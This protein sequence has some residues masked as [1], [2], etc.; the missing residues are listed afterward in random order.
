MRFP[1]PLPFSPP[2]PIAELKVVVVP[3][4]QRLR[5]DFGSQAHPRGL[6]PRRLARHLLSPP[7][8]CH[9]APLCPDV[10]D[11]LLPDIFAEEASLGVRDVGDLEDVFLELLVERRVLGVGDL[12]WRWVMRREVYAS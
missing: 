8:V 4:L 11:E 3:K 5:E 2:E 6:H 9:R 12:G 10:R 1:A 7:R